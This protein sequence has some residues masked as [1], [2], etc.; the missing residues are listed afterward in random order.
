MAFFEILNA[1]MHRLIEKNGKNK[2]TQ[3]T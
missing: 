2:C 3:E 1:T